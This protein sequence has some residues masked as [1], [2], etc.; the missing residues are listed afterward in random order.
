M[1]ICC[2]QKFGH[3]HRQPDLL[4][5]VFAYDV[6]SPNLCRGDGCEK[7]RRQN[8]KDGN[9]CEQLHQSEAA[10]AGDRTEIPFL[11]TGVLSWGERSS[12]GHARVLIRISHINS[13]CETVGE[14]GICLMTP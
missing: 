1:D 13:N 4:Q 9:H 6:S 11:N 10:L 7:Q 5:V 8:S 12:L 3:C 14:T 2:F